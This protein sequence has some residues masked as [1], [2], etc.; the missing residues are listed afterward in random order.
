[1]YE[2]RPTAAEL[3]GSSLLPEDFEQAH[4][5]LWPDNWPSVQLFSQLSTQWRVG[6]GGV[7]GLDYGV[8]FHELDRRAIDSDEYDDM[9]GAI[10]MIEGVALSEIH[11]A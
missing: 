11:K 8:V 7:V 10:R 6:P 9:M 5:D 2:K 1:M 3:A 4:V